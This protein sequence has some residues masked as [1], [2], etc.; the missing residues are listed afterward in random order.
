MPLCCIMD[1]NGTNKS[2]SSFIVSYGAHWK[3]E[4]ALGHKL[5][6]MPSCCTI[7]TFVDFVFYFRRGVN[8]WVWVT[9]L[10]ISLL[11]PDIQTL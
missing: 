4:F 1:L 3:S 2:M 8:P 10:F 7:W 11:D 9:V 6:Y 5:I